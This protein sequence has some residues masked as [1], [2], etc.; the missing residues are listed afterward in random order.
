MSKLSQNAWHYP[1]QA[2]A[3]RYLSAFDLGLESARG[4]FAKRRMGKTEFLTKDLIPAAAKAGYL[5]A[6]ANL[7][8][9]RDNPALALIE[10][11]SLAFEPQG[12]DKLLRGLKTPIK[13]IKASG[14]VAGMEGGLE[15]ELS[16]AVTP[17]SVLTTLLRKFDKSGKKLLLTIDEAQVLAGAAHTSFAHALRAALDVRKESI[18][19]IFAGS[20]ENTLR[21]MFARASEPFYNWASLEPFELLSRDFVEAMAAKV[22]ALCRY[23]LTEKAALTAFA[24]LNNTPDFFRR[25]LT[26]YMLHAQQGAR[27]ALNATKEQ[28]F[29]D[30]AFINYW[31]SLLPADKEILKMLAEGGLDLH[32]KLARTR[33]GAALGLD[34]PVSL[35][36]PQQALKRLQADTVV[37]RLDHGEYCFEDDAFAQWV[38]MLDV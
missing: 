9:N 33:L 11:L 37:T 1:R 8:D 38:R 3:Q 32:G 16:D 2:L 20:S 6:Y 35:N 31:K 26:Q 19:V 14:K 7:W 22:N 34:A 15:A 21:R 25:F 5:T 30:V 24:E 17:G 29:N 10:A 28:V 23:P 4:I 18:K 13:K 36:T 12:M 27:A